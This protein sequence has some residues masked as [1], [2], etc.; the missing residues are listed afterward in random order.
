MLTISCQSAIL[1]S[2]RRRREG[3]LGVAGKR[4]LLWRLDQSPPSGIGR[5]SSLPP[6]RGALGRLDEDTCYGDATPLRL[7][8]P[9]RT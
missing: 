1:V 5:L 3:S 6:A 8:S 4:N 9:P 2:S 7:S